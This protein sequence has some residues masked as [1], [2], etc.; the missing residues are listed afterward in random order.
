MCHDTWI[1]ITNQSF[2]MNFPVEVRK[3]G[4]VKTERCLKQGKLW[5]F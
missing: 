3:Q 4:R 2:H 1:S 5:T